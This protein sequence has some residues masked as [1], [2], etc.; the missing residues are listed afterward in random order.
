MFI[1]A[2]LLSTVLCVKN[3][4]MGSDFTSGAE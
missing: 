2:S 1:G 3:F 4:L